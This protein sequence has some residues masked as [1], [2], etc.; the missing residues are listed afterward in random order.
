MRTIFELHVLMQVCKQCNSLYGLTH[1]HII[2]QNAIDFI[3]V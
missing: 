2:C 1:T 3:L